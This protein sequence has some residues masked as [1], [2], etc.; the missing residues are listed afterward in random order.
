MAPIAPG[1]IRPIPIK[2]HHT[3]KPGEL[4]KVVESPCTIAL[5]GEREV[6]VRE[7]SRY[8]IKLQMDG[9]L[10]VDIHRALRSAVKKRYAM[11]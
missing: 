1:L 5:D 7:S 3:I 9:P 10:V 6:E 2:S 4:I 8:Y 11:K